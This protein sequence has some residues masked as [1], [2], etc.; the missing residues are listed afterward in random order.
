MAPSPYNGITFCQ[1][2]FSAMRVEI[3]AN[4]RRFGRQGTLGFVHFR[5]VIG[6]AARFSDT[7]HGEGQTD[8]FEAMRAYDEIGFAGPLRLDPAPTMAGESNDRPGYATLGCLYAIGS[9]KGLLEGVNTT[10]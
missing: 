5:D 4:I 10:A 7:F 1:G 3:P 8:M 6:T 2:N 9:I